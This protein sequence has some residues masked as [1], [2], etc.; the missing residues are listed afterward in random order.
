M[1]TRAR[2]AVGGAGS[3]GV[4]LRRSGRLTCRASPGPGGGDPGPVAG[5]G[6]PG[7]GRAARARSRRTARGAGGVQE[8]VPPSVGAAASS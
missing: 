6:D 1:G 7:P 8:D 4:R 3:H 2:A 5:G